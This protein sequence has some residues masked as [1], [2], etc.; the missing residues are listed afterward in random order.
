MTMS[1]TI[2]HLAAV[3]QDGKALAFV[4]EALRTAEL[5]L[6]A[7]RQ[8]GGALQHVPEELRTPGLE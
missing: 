4:S 8:N 3:R 2:D 6:E 1:N 5:C 7:V